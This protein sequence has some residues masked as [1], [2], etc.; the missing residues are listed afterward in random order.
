[1]AHY[2]YVLQSVSLNLHE[3]RMRTS[4]DPYSQVWELSPC[5]A[6]TFGSPG[7]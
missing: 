5:C 3:R 2:L 4:V 6:S 7:G 1:M